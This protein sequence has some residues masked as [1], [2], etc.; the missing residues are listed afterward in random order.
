MRHS[1]LG[2]TT[3]S[4]PVGLRG[5]VVDPMALSS[6]LDLTILTTGTRTSVLLSLLPCTVEVPQNL[7]DEEI[8]LEGSEWDLDTRCVPAHC[9]TLL[10]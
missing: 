6:A 9:V 2:R 8:P 4:H 3:K 10:R 7:G 1:A 5:H